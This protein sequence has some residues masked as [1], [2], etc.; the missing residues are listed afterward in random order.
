MVSIYQYGDSF[1][2]VLI[3][4]NKSND[5]PDY[6]SMDSWM[7]EMYEQMTELIESTQSQPTDMDI[8]LCEMCEMCEISEPQD[9]LMA[10]LVVD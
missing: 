3:Y 5:I 4:T 9:D 6:G 8:M 1:D 2:D 7:H 10:L